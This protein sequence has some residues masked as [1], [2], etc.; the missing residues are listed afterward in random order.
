MIKI[1]KRY[2]TF[3]LIKKYFGILSILNDL[4]LSERPIELVSYTL[5]Y[6]Y[7]INRENKAEYQKMFKCSEQTINSSMKVL[8]NANILVKK[9]GSVFINPALKISLVEDLVLYITLENDQT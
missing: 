7:P 3:E 8:L 5:L 4:D 9:D 1:R 2:I 6:G